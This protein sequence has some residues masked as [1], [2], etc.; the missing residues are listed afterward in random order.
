M[1]DAILNHQ[2]KIIHNMKNLFIAFIAVFLVVGTAQAQDGKKL[3]KNA[4][5]AIGLKLK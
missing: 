2:I 4:K 1:Q 5:K 3:L